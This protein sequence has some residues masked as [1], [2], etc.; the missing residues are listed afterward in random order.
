[1]KSMMR[2]ILVCQGLMERCALACMPY[3]KHAMLT[4]LQLQVLYQSLV[5]WGQSVSAESPLAFGARQ[6]P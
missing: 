2:C 5:G 3:G 6:D 4:A 1:M